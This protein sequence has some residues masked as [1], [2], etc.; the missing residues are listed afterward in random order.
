MFTDLF[1]WNK[2]MTKQ[3]IFITAP[4]PTETGIAKVASFMI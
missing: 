3:N 2:G 1:L 4:P